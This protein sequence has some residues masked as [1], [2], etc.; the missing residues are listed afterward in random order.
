MNGAC[1]FS[2]KFFTGLKSYLVGAVSQMKNRSRYGR[3]IALGLKRISQSD[4]AAVVKSTYGNGY[5]KSSILL[6]LIIFLGIN[7]YLVMDLMEGSLH[8]VIHG[9][10]PMEDDLI[11]HF[12][13]QILRGL[14]VIVC[15]LLLLAFF[16]TSY[17]KVGSERNFRLPSCNT[18]VFS[19][20]FAHSQKP[21]EKSKGYRL[22]ISFC[23]YRSYTEIVSFQR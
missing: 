5:P 10:G 6:Y 2:L 19:I 20:C 15:L 4:F 7:V 18:A 8:H 13:Y 22:G 23:V 1:V 9:G 16:N 3:L 17:V 12:L 11:A 14:R 21:T